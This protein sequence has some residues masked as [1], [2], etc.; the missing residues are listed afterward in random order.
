MTSDG[1]LYSEK[2]LEKWWTDKDVFLSPKTNVVLERPEAYA[3]YGVREHIQTLVSDCVQ[4]G[5]ARALAA[6]KETD[7]FSEALLMHTTLRKFPSTPSDDDLYQLHLLCKDARLRDF[8]CACGALDVASAAFFSRQNSDTSRFL[9]RMLSFNA[10]HQERLAFVIP[11]AILGTSCKVPEAQCLCFHVLSALVSDQSVISDE[12]THNLC[13]ILAPVVA[14]KSVVEGVAPSLLLS[15]MLFLVHLLAPQKRLRR[16]AGG[17]DT[18]ALVVRKLS[19]LGVAAMPVYVLTHM[20]GDARAAGVACWLAALLADLDPAFGRTLREQA[21]LEVENASKSSQCAFFAML[22]LKAFREPQRAAMA[23]VQAVC[24]HAAHDRLLGACTVAVSILS[25]ATAAESEVQA[26]VPSITNIVQYVCKTGLEPVV[27]TVKKMSRCGAWENVQ[28]GLKLFFNMLCA[29]DSSSM[30]PAAVWS[31]AGGVV[32]ALEHA[33]SSFENFEGSFEHVVVFRQ[34]ALALRECMRI[35]SDEQL[36]RIQLREDVIAL[37]FD[38]VENAK[39]WEEEAS[40][41]TSAGKAKQLAYAR[42]FVG[43]AL[44]LVGVVCARVDYFKIHSNKVSRHLALQLQHF[45]HQHDVSLQIAHVLQG[46][47]CSSLF[48]PELGRRAVPARSKLYA[49]EMDADMYL[50]LWDVLQAVSLPETLPLKLQVL[51]V[52]RDTAVHVD[53]RCSENMLRTMH[54]EIREHVDG[55]TRDAALVVKVCS[56][57]IANMLL[58][59]ESTRCRASGSETSALM[60]EVLERFSEFTCADV[61]EQALRVLV[62]L[63]QGEGAPSFSAEQLR[64]VTRAMRAVADL[65]EK[66]RAE[67]VLGFDARRRCDN[68][69][70][71]EVACSVPLYLIHRVRDPALLQQCAK[72]LL[73]AEMVDVVVDVLHAVA[74]GDEEALTERGQETATCALQALTPALPKATLLRVSETF[75]GLLLKNSRRASEVDQYGAGRAQAPPKKKARRAT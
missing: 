45:R 56:E 12:V 11:F 16:T 74:Q 38:V 5:K 23:A 50:A 29:T 14:D 32:A 25:D 61:L 40:L 71:L 34:G 48:D 28:D 31:L 53:A 4:S 51:A 27:E 1:Q 75:A 57:T 26:G 55:R 39:T 44:E 17:R 37:L 18:R 15:A 64:L 6:L 46:L 19:A 36:L 66:Q 73:D 62:F 30:T 41:S 54:A 69:H 67:S 2:A 58:G 70:F 24:D 8:A 20:Q 65:P 7:V 10:E 68:A 72:M 60:F 33:H 63:V 59:P 49:S 9:L 21:Y 42:G 22:A 13:Q 47:V 3:A 35:M 52:L 43:E